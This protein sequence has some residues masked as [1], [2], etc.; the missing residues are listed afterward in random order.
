MWFIRGKRRGGIW[1]ERKD[2]IFDKKAFLQASCSS[3]CFDQEQ[4]PYYMLNK[5]LV[6]NSFLGTPAPNSPWP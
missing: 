1:N 4:S 2:F 6:P 5:R 3:T